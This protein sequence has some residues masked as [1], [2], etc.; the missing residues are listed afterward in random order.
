[1]SSGIENQKC[2]TQTINKREKRFF[3]DLTCEVLVEATAATLPEAM[4]FGEALADP[5]GTFLASHFVKLAIWSG[6]KLFRRLTP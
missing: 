6:F 1:M 3:V 5:T 4:L 2:A